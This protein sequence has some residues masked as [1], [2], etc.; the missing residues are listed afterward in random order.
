MKSFKSLPKLEN[1]FW[2]VKCEEC[3]KLFKYKD[4][5]LELKETIWFCSDSCREAYCKKHH[6]KECE[7]C[8]LK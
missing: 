5:S 3:G 1:D 6:K 8:E 4:A 2:L 7:E